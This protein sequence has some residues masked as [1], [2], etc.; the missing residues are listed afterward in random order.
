MRERWV[1]P[2]FPLSLSPSHVKP[3]A[4]LIF[5]ALVVVTT[6]TTDISS[7]S[8]KIPAM[9]LANQGEA[10]AQKKEGKHRPTVMILGRVSYVC[11]RSRY[12]KRGEEGFPFFC[13]WKIRPNPLS[14]C[15]KLFVQDYADPRRQNVVVVLLR[16]PAFL[17]FFLLR[18]RFSGCL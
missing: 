5:F 18:R 9:L 1:R 10:M 17:T 2:F 6:T 7:F 13:V 8:P 16:P 15:D 14:L 11:A 4:S 12:C 3:R